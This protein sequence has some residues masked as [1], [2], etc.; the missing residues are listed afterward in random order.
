MHFLTVPELNRGKL[1][2]IRPGV[3]IYYFKTINGNYS[4]SDNLIKCTTT[5][6]E[7]ELLITNGCEAE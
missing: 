2:L 1:E 3:D 5:L 7:A 4:Y 6:E